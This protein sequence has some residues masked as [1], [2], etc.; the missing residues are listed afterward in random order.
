[1]NRMYLYPVNYFYTTP[2]GINGQVALANNPAPQDSYKITFRV[3]DAGNASAVSLTVT[4]NI[5]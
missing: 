2:S 1:M 4:V 5:S 3:I